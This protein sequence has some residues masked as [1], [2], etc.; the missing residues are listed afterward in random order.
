MHLQANDLCVLLTGGYVEVFNKLAHRTDLLRQC[1]GSDLDFI[2]LV[3]LELVFV[4]W[5]WA[6]VRG[7]IIKGLLSSMVIVVCRCILMLL[8]IQ[9]FVRGCPTQHARLRIIP[10]EYLLLSRLL[11]MLLLLLHSTEDIV[12]DWLAW[13]RWLATINSL[14]ELHQA[15]EHMVG[16]SFICS[17]GCRT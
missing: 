11:M 14:F 5:R 17:G 13:W 7:R 1:L 3:L 4:I 8:L 2:Q 9:K 12:A 6:L 15:L 16:N 10:I